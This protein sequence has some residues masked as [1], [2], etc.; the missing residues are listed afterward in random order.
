MGRCILLWD[1]RGPSKHPPSPWLPQHRPPQLP[2][3][4]GGCQCPAPTIPPACY[5]WNRSNKLLIEELLSTCEPVRIKSLEDNRY[6]M[7]TTCSKTQITTTVTE[8]REGL[9]CLLWGG[10]LVLAHTTDL[11]WPVLCQ[12]CPGLQPPAGWEIPRERMATV[13]LI[14]FHLWRK[15]RELNIFDVLYKKRSFFTNVTSLFQA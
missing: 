13:G 5:V 9:S 4:Q 14:P 3:S 7:N 10:G 15:Q 12:L 1:G 11:Q 6:N 2:P 8:R